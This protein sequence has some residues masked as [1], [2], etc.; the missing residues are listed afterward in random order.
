MVFLV[1]LLYFET[2]QPVLDQNEPYVDI[3]GRPISSIWRLNRVYPTYNIKR[4][5]ISEYLVCRFVL[6]SRQCVSLGSTR[7]T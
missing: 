5:L 6:F 7:Y 1:D 2:R 3:A 4:G